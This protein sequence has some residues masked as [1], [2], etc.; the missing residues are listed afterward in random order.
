MPDL[1]FF[2][3]FILGQ[4]LIMITIILYD[5]YYDLILR[6]L[7]IDDV[8]TKIIEHFSQNFEF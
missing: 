5:Y 2:G 1:K 8:D 3:C 7:C 6:V 4:I